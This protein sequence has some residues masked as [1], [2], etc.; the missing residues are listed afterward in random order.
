[1]FCCHVLWVFRRGSDSE[2]LYAF[3]SRKLYLEWKEKI[4]GMWITK[5]HGVFLCGTDVLVVSEAVQ[6]RRGR[7]ILYW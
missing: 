6:V 1:V 5:Q 3:A 4:G 7:R 2:L